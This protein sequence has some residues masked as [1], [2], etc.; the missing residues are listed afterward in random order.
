MSTQKIYKIREGTINKPYS[1]LI[2]DE[3]DT[4]VEISGNS[5]VI[6]EVLNK[7]KVSIYAGNDSRVW[8]YPRPNC[9]VSALSF[10]HAR[11]WDVRRC[12]VLYHDGKFVRKPLTS[13]ELTSCF[14]HFYNLPV[15]NDKVFLFKCVRKDYKDYY[16]GKLNYLPGTVVEAEDWSPIN[17]IVCGNGL[18][19]APTKQTALQW[20]EDGRILNCEVNVNDISIFPYNISQARCK[21]I[22]VKSEIEKIE[23]GGQ[24]YD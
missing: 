20:N 23:I 19:L 14:I 7:S 8:L 22:F 18:H 2:S 16:T 6:I 11:I 15:F 24:D 17:N 5:N 13:F 1:L 21:K 12:H 3:K 4:I 10:D 9:E